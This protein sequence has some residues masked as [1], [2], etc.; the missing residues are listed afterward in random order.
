M[1]RE[2]LWHADVPVVVVS[3]S[4][5]VPHGVEL[6]SPSQ[7][8]ASWP[9]QNLSVGNLN[10]RIKLL[11]RFIVRARGLRWI[12]DNRLHVVTTR[13]DLPTQCQ[14]CLWTYRP[15]KKNNRKLSPWFRRH[16]E[17]RKHT[18]EHPLLPRVH[19]RCKR[20]KQGVRPRPNTLCPWGCH[21]EVFLAKDQTQHLKWHPESEN[22]VWFQ[23]E[24]EGQGG[25]N[26]RGVQSQFVLHNILS[27]NG[28]WP[29]RSLRCVPLTLSFMALRAFF[30]DTVV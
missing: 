12:R 9:R 19:A 27:S 10:L 29:N 4:S 13:K 17:T 14:L 22:L 3:V 25:Q 21:S 1:P 26:S 23:P 24:Q 2:S 20:K 7:Q 6:S 5:D 28:A 8:L 16:N 18:F 15:C 11:N 30:W